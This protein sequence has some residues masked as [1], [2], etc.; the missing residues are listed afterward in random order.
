MHGADGNCAAFQVQ[1]EQ[2]RI[3]RAEYH[4]TPCVTLV[5][6]CEHLSELAAG[7]SLEDARRY[8]P[9]VLLG[10]HPEIPAERRDRATLA[11]E[12]FRTAVRQISPGSSN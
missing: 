4:C 7:I 2:G 1:T 3:Q 12:A 5:A 10:Y 11:V 8:E 9:Q 6:L